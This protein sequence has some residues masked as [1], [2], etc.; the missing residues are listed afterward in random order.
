MELNYK[1]QGHNAYNDFMVERSVLKTQALRI[2]K[3]DF[4]KT[5]KKCILLD[6]LYIQTGVSPNDYEAERLIEAMADNILKK[7][8]ETEDYCN[9]RDALYDIEDAIT[10]L[11]RA[12]SDKVF[13]KVL[14]NV[15]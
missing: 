11:V 5:L 6:A 4:S 3:K 8:G 2:A 7:I 10:D 12:E 9:Y 14:D 1:S 13:D 15:K